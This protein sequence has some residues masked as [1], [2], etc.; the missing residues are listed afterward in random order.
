MKKQSQQLG[1]N[2]STASNRL[3]KDLLFKFVQIADYTCYRCKRKLTRETFSIDHIEAWLDS[4]DPISKFFDLGNIAFSH[5]SCNAGAGKRNIV[6]TNW[7]MQGKP[8]RHPSMVAGD[9][10][11]VYDS[12]KR[13]EQYRRTG[14]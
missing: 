9:K 3:V 5:F 12:Q 11:R 10:R 13:R 7:Y 6:H 1:M 8:G 4:E 14:K 2:V